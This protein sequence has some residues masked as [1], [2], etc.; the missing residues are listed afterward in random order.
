[1]NTQELPGGRTVRIRADEIK[2]LRIQKGWSS[3]ELADRAI[4]SVKTIE[5]IERG[6]E[7]YLATVAKV[8]KALGEDVATLLKKPEQ[9]ASGHPVTADH[10]WK[11]DVTIKLSIPSFDQF[12][13]TKDLVDLIKLLKTVIGK[14]SVIAIEEVTDG[15]VVV[16]LKIANNEDIAKKLF[17]RIQGKTMRRIMGV[18]IPLSTMFDVK[19]IRIQYTSQPTPEREPRSTLP[20]VAGPSDFAGSL[21]INDEYDKEIEEY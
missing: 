21:E 19:E 9:G 18:P 15:S 12:D 6:R 8:A 20:Y 11:F 14:H 4:C 7:V 17:E 1:M 13:E 2:R 10:K 5:N 3:K 16:K